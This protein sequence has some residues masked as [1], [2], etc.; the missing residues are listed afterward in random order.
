MESRYCVSCGR[1]IDANSLVCPY[2][3][4]DR[5][6]MVYP[7]LPQEE[8]LSGGERALFYILSLLIPIAGIII[9]A[10]YISKN[11]P[12][13]K[14]VGKICL[15]LALVAF[16]LS[17]AM[18]AILYAMVLGFGGDD[19][20]VSTPVAAY[21]RITI[22]DGVDV[23]V[24][25]ITAP[26]IPWSDVMVQLSTGTALASWN[27]TTS[28][29]EG[30]GTTSYV[31]G[32]RTLDALTVR[33]EVFDIAGNGYVNGADHFR[34]TTIGTSPSFSSTD[35]YNAVLIYEPTGERIGSGVTFTG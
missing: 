13:L 5:L 12:Q 20:H 10:I 23:T 34:L 29:L 31:V 27:P 21:S 7:A 4:R 32:D 8:T 30:S 18:A 1:A 33:C 35:T 25:V 14:R 24:V 22:T 19:G 3:G 6:A 26:D 17:Y 16:L 15:A 9:G 28:A 2:C 11:S